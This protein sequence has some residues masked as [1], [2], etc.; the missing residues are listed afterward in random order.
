MRQVEGSDRTH[1]CA[2]CQFL[3]AAPQ[4]AR[5]VGG[6][7]AGYLYLKGARFN[8]MAELKYRYVKWKINRT[9]KRFDIYPGG[10]KDDI[11]R[12]IH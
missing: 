6:L 4:T 5:F 8:L 11:N 2:Q 7:V 1:D 12:R 9:R 3:R 10:R